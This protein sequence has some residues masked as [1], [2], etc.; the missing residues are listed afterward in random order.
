M[1]SDMDYVA[2]QV[3][4]YYPPPLTKEKTSQNGPSRRFFL[5]MNGL[6]LVRSFFLIKICKPIFLFYQFNMI[7][8]ELERERSRVN[9]RIVDT[10]KGRH[11]IV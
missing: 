11:L 9:I 8:A 2:G 7:L 1:F 10:N 3:F 5:Q 4:D 6:F